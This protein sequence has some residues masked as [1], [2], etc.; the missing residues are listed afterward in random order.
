M[1]MIEDIISERTYADSLRDITL[2]LESKLHG[3]NENVVAFLLKKGV[4][5]DE[6]LARLGG[7]KRDSDPLE[8][9]LSSLS[10]ST[11]QHVPAQSKLDFDKN[12]CVQLRAQGD[13]SLLVSSEGE[14]A[15]VE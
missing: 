11:S 7:T 6:F 12:F 5:P 15:T 8:L 14:A 9:S 1:K 13:P 10:S 4:D 3:Y 2:Q